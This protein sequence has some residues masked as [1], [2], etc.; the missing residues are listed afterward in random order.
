M[1]KLLKNNQRFS[2]IGVTNGKDLI[3]EFKKNTNYN[4]III[5]IKLPLM[6]GIECLKEIRKINKNVPVIAVTAFLENDD[7]RKFLKHGFTAFIPK[8]FKLK[9]FYQKVTGILKLHPTI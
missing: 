3:D 4:A 8:P 7:E 9:D 1:E 6:N 2:C 5:D